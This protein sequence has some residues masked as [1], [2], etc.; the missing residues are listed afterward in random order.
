MSTYACRFVGQERLSNRL[1]DFDLDRFF[2]LG[3]SSFSVQ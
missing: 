1:S 2:Q 3:V